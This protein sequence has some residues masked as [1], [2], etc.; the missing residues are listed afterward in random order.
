[1]ETVRGAASFAALKRRFYFEHR[2]GEESFAL[3]PDDARDFRELL[4]QAREPDEVLRRDLM[5]AL[6]LCF[7]PK[8]FPGCDDA[9][10]LWIGHRFHEQP[11]RCFLANQSIR[12]T[13]IQVWVPR[14][15][16]RLSGAFTYRPEHFVL[17]YLPN[18][19]GELCRLNVDFPLWATLRKLSV[20]F[21][22]HFAAE[23]ELNRVDAFL[24]EIM[25][26]NPQQGR[27]FV[28]FN[29]EDRLVTR[30]TLSNDYRQYA[31]IESC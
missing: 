16:R 7:C 17:E 19:G 18:A 4:E 23:R 26:T 21:P 1:M 11:S 27:V 14:L 28:A 30:V 29:N 15:P 20:G 5:R 31:D 24:N 2:H 6:N 8:S 9:F 13:E 25:G 22:R 3:E 10:W 12:A